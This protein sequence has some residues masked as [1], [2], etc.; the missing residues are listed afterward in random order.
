M[1]N[2]KVI[3]LINLNVYPYFCLYKNLIFLDWCKFKQN[4]IILN[5][6]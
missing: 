2:D 6:T 5:I 3:T 1:F 4:V